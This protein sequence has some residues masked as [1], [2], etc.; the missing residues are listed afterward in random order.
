MTRAELAAI[1]IG[2]LL[3]MIAEAAVNN[4]AI[5]FSRYLW[6]DELQAKLVE[7]QPGIW[8]SMTVLAHSGDIT[9]PTYH[10]I[11]RAS[12]WLAGIFGGSAETAWR[13]L[14]FAAIWLG[15][16]LTYAVLRRSFATLPSLIAVLM[17]WACPLTVWCAFFAR[18]YAL[19]MASSAGF[20]FAWC[21]EDSHPVMTAFFAMLMCALHYF[22]I[23]ALS[24]III[25][26][27]VIRHQSW[28][29]NL[30][31]LLP[32][33][34]GPLVLL[35]LMP[36]FRAQVTGY[37]QRAWLPPLTW[38]FASG[39]IVS[40]FYLP[41]LVVL[42]LLGAWWVSGWIK[43]APAELSVAQLKEVMRPVA[44]MLG[45]LLV[46]LAV[47]M[48][49]FR[50]NHLVDRYLITALLG[51][52]PVAAVLGSHLSR[53]VQA[54]AL[55]VVIVLGAHSMRNLGAEHTRW[56][57]DEED[58]VEECTAMA[59]DGYPLISLTSHEAYLLYEYAPD[60]RKKLLIVDLRPE[61]RSDMT[62]LALNDG[63]SSARWQAVIP[64][65]PH[66]TTL[67]DLRR[68]GK[69]HVVFKTEMPILRNGFLPFRKVDGYGTSGVFR[70][71]PRFHGAT[72]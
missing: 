63:T 34:T 16:I 48:I 32:A 23:F 14:S 46:P 6:F 39:V 37:E 15:L 10:L 56:Q 51:F 53:W 71:D 27:L 11:A 29:N 43:S 33:A 7:S 69:F 24:A 60:L 58:M 8:H 17:V 26:D 12:W 47:L 30:R 40:T 38:D 66:Q 45:L 41:V 52:A 54:A 1:A 64:D 59:S 21:D 18:P 49:S 2:V 42:I 44:G 61:L 72:P 62:E 25:G 3:L 50:E 19:L 13:L 28:R 68:I 35:L 55:V 31:R 4:P 9:P 20:C 5:L 57:A 65:L 36:F 70:I 67:D 22:G